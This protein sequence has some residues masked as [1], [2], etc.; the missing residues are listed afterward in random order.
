MDDILAATTMESKQTAAPASA[1]A[2]A[3]ALMETT[4]PTGSK[5]VGAGGRKT[6]AKAPKKVLAKEEKDVEAAKGWGRRKNLKER[7]DASAVARQVRV[8]AQLADK[9]R[10][11]AR[12]TPCYKRSLGPFHICSPTLTDL[13]WLAR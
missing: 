12:D 2:A 10:R 11:P 9:M 4:S 13:N 1:Q 7:K 3:L 6:K 8:A 5:R